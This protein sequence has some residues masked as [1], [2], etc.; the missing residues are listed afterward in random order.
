M[1]GRKLTCLLCACDRDF[2]SDYR[3]RTGQKNQSQLQPNGIPKSAYLE[4]R[5]REWGHWRP[6]SI[7]GW[8]PGRVHRAFSDGPLDGRRRHKMHNI[9]A[10]GNSHACFARVIETSSRIIVGVPAKKP[11][12]AS[13]K[14]NSEKRISGAQDEVMGPLASIE[15]SR[16][17]TRESPSSIL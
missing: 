6:S 1:C 8:I 14:R 3:R 12:S 10:A 2:Q 9:C 15:H 7:L 13:T 17:D 16:I 4:H 11:I 5:T